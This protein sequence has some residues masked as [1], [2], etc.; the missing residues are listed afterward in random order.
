[1]AG[2]GMVLF[3]KR[4]MEMQ[5]S[6]RRHPEQQALFKTTMPCRSTNVCITKLVYAHLF[7]FLGHF[8]LFL[9]QDKL[10]K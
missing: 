6:I 2:A 9:A 4:T 5:D 7:S 3:G 10:S 8:S 1:L